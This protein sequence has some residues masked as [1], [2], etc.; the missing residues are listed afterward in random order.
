MDE[1]C[2][3]TLGVCGERG[4]FALLGL[5]VRCGGIVHIDWDSLWLWLWVL[6]WLLVL[7]V[8]LLLLMLMMNKLCMVLVVEGLFAVV[9]HRRRSVRRD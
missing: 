3:E 4:G 7:L 5:L 8:L 6:L 9:L 2:V 1:Y